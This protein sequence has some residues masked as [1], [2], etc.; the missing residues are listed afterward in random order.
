MSHIGARIKDLRIK[1]QLSQAE[2]G[3]EVG[4]YQGMISA[5]EIGRANPSWKLAKRLAEFFG[6][7]LA[8]LI[9]EPETEPVHA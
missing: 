7:E 6:M 3:R 1:R 2:L 5:I 9:A 4:V 8:D